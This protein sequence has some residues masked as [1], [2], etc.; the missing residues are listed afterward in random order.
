MSKPNNTRENSGKVI[1]L[2]QT[3]SR[4]KQIIVLVVLLIASYMITPA[5]LSSKNVFYLTRIASIIGIATLGMTIVILTGGIDLSI[6]SIAALSCV[7]LAYFEHWGIYLGY[8]EE[9]SFIAPLPIIYLMCLGVGALV[10]LFYGYIIGKWNL[11]DFAVTLGGLFALKGISYIIPGGQT[12]FGVDG[13][14]KFLGGGG[15]GIIPVS[16]LIWIGIAV[17]VY[18]LLNYTTIG[19]AVYA[20]GGGR[21]ASQMCGISPVKVKMFAYAICGIL[22]AFVGIIYAGRTDTGD[23]RVAGTDL[24]VNAL[25]AT[26]LGGVN[27]FGGQGSIAGVLIGSV[28]VAMIFNVFDLTGLHPYPRDVLRGIALII[29]LASLVKGEKLKKA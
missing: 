17:F 27:I 6:G 11:P 2:K 7:L 25:M 21:D 15:I 29:I 12:I 24:M 22:A 1:N 8:V 3:L 10:G 13:F 23:Y 5:F 14:T 16:F 4:Y 28:I 26:L 18:I 19:K 9:L 20:Y